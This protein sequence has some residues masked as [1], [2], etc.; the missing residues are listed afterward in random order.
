MHW[1]RAQPRAGSYPPEHLLNLLRAVDVEG[2]L[3]R[4][5]RDLDVRAV[6]L[7]LHD[8]L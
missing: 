1:Q 2:L 4:D 7:L 5:G 3:L 8:L 6:D